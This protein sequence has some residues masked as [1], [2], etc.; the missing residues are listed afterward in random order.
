M[1]IYAQSFIDTYENANAKEVLRA[2]GLPQNF[3]ATLL[4]KNEP[5]TGSIVAQRLAHLLGNITFF[6][7]QSGFDAPAAASVPE[8]FAKLHQKAPTE[9][10]SLAEDLRKDLSDSFTVDAV[11][12]AKALE[13]QKSREAQEKDEEDLQLVYEGYGLDTGKASLITNL[14]PMYLNVAVV[15]SVAD[16]AAK[17]FCQSLA[18][19][20]YRTPDIDMPLYEVS[21]LMFSKASELI[22]RYFTNVRRLDDIE[23]NKVELT[24]PIKSEHNKIIASNQ[25][26][27]DLAAA[28]GLEKLPPTLF[29]DNGQDGKMPYW[30]STQLSCFLECDIELQ[31]QIGE[32]IVHSEGKIP[33]PLE[34]IEQQFLDLLPNAIVAMGY[35]DS[36]EPFPR[37]LITGLYQDKVLSQQAIELVYAFHDGDFMHTNQFKFAAAML[38]QHFGIER[39]EFESKDELESEPRHPYDDD[40]TPSPDDDGGEPAV[41]HVPKEAPETKV[42]SATVFEARRTAKAK[43]KD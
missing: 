3:A 21:K 14:P 28:L 41:A 35:E 19:Q 1:T 42:V 4:P 2:C 38:A 26:V 16:E 27:E 11:Y 43:G 32:T 7:D 36:A 15:T 22:A 29:G 33:T 40:D 8:W 25:F 24:A 18:E 17:T 34:A 20:D 9:L 5:V 37:Y 10:L 13:L 23:H 6:L 39:S 12:L 30:M 31:K